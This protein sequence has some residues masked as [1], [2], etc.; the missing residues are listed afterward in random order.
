M[1]DLG[2]RS[3][4]STVT[5]TEFLLARIARTEAAIR[6]IK[7]PYRLYVDEDGCIEEPVRLDWPDENAGQY[8]QWESGEDRLPNH[9]NTWA[10]IYD[11]ARVLARC[12]ADRQI[13]EEHAPRVIRWR[14]SIDIYDD[15][16]QTC[17]GS[18]PGVYPCDTL[19]LLA[20][21]CADHPDYQEAWKP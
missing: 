1:S 4:R 10:L 20:L 16:C 6:R 17:H 8:E 12:E 3:G 7:S 11:P 19:R 2:V 13:V 9:H 14:D 18:E 15:E 5:I 21:F